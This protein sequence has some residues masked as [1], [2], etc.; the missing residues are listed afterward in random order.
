[1]IELNHHHINK[2]TKKGDTANDIAKHYK[3]TEHD[4][5]WK[6]AQ[7]LTCSLNDEQRFTL[8]SWFMKLETN[9]LNHRRTLPAAYESLIQDTERASQ[10]QNRR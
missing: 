8:E 4:I 3:K 7:C 9:P 5:D 10:I 1:M 6:S 2:A